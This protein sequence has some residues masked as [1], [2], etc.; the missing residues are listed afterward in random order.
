MKFL[1]AWLLLLSTLAQADLNVC[2]RM[3][4]TAGAANQ[5][6]SAISAGGAVTLAS[7]TVVTAP[8]TVQ[9]FTSSTGT[10]NKN[11]TFVITS[12][13]ATVGAT[14]TNN[15]VTF[16]VYATVASATQVVMSGSGPPA[17]SGTLTKS[18]GTGDS[19][20][21][22]SQFLAPLYLK[23]R[24]VG[25][26]GGGGG[27]ADNSN[28]GG[29]GGTGGTTYFRVGASPDLLV[30]TGGTGGSGSGSNSTSNGGAASLGTGPIGTALTGGSGSGGGQTP[31]G[32]GNALPGGA[33][34][35]SAFGGGGAGGSTTQ[36]GLNG[37]TNTGGGGG[38]S[39]AAAQ[40]RSGQ[41]GG[42][43][44][45]VDAL[46]ASP[47]ASYAYAVGAGGLAGTLGTSGTAGG[48]GGSGYIEVT[49]Y[50]Q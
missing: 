11:Y 19:T 22:F 50:Y 3:P 17:S 40:G 44:G 7:P 41:G 2:P 5:F 38:G 36:A 1:T 9:K 6:V 24:L 18:A 14:Y 21:T 4:V 13:S 27:G 33:G 23:V 28:T 8:P 43:G 20:L 48:V 15:A 39:A 42:A 47:A 32:A 25:G 37:V 46:I 12:G 10:Y 30:G 49:E 29:T 45:Y 26:G 31:T 16:T 34:G 35:N